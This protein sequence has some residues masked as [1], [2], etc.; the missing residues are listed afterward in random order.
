MR[1]EALARS[2]RTRRTSAQFV[3][4][5]VEMRGCAQLIM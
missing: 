1:R 3:E 2:P 5:R 4:H